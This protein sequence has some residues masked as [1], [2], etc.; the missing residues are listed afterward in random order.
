MQSLGG[1][2]KIQGISHG[3]EIT[4]MS[5]LHKIDLDTALASYIPKV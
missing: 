1:P 4:E 5:K 3:K 2:G